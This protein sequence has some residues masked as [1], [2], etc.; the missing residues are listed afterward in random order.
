MSQLDG[1]VEAAVRKAARTCVSTAR[2]TKVALSA[3]VT[4]SKSIFRALPSMSSTNDR[5][6]G[7]DSVPRSRLTSEARIR[8]NWPMSRFGRRR[9]YAVLDIS[10]T[11]IGRMMTWMPRNWSRRWIENAVS[12]CSERVNRFS[13]WNTSWPANTTGRRNSFTRSTTHALELLHQSRCR[14]RTR[15]SAYTPSRVSRAGRTR[16]RS[17]RTYSLERPDLVHA[18]ELRGVHQPDRDEHE[19]PEVTR[20]QPLDREQRCGCRGRRRTRP[21]RSRSGRRRRAPARTFGSG[22][23]Q[24]RERLVERRQHVADAAVVAPDRRSRAR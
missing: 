2:A 3:A 14:A 23:R 16:S 5:S 11:R 12:W 24:V 18:L 21:A 13:R 17:R 22:E 7:S 10:H 4:S 1:E 6:M 8:F 19:V 20:E 9:R 15:Y